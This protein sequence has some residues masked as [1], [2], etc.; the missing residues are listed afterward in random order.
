MRSFAIGERGRATR[1][2]AADRTLGRLPSHAP[3]NYDCPFCRLVSGGET[4][5]SRQ[6]DIVLRERGT[7]AFV[8]AKWWVNNPGHVLV[9]PDSHVENVYEIPDE[10]LGAVY[11]TAKAIAAA[12]R[13]TYDCSGTSMRQ[14]NEPAGNQDVWH[15]H[16]HVFPRHLGDRLYENHD[17]TRWPDEGERALYA[18]RLRTYLRA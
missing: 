15:F 12:M 7:T 10:T 9:V 17:G 3:P 2:S 5:H 18:E 14:H 1:P 6:S 11:G 13:A 8:A 16:V 4:E